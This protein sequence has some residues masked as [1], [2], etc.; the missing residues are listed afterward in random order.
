[1]AVGTPPSNE[2]GP[3]RPLA[4]PRLILAGPTPRK[5]QVINA[6]LRSNTPATNPPQKI[7]GTPED[8]ETA[9]V[10]EGAFIRT[11]IRFS[12]SYE[13]QFSLYMLLARRK[14]HPLMASAINALA[15]SSPLCER[16]ITLGAWSVTT[17]N[18]NII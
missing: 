7:A 3:S 9:T 17:H 14:A 16:T 11:L 13:Y 5:P 18:K 8:L 12:K 1:M 6:E 10:V 2:R 4:I 15:H